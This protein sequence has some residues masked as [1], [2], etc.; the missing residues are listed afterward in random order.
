[1]VVSLQFCWSIFQ[2]SATRPCEWCAFDKI[3]WGPSGVQLTSRKYVIGIPRE[4]GINLFINA[5]LIVLTEQ[6]QASED[7]EHTAMLKQLRNTDI[8]RP[9][10]Q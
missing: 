1:M 4:K 3:S 5:R 8:A 2:F 6:M 7:S 10:T 9:V